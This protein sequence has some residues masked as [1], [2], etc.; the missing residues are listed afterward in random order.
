MHR[1]P[2]SLRESIVH[3]LARVWVPAAVAA[4]VSALAAPA[5]ATTFTVK[6]TCSY[7][8]FPAVCRLCS[9]GLKFIFTA[10]AI[11]PAIPG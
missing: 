8:V 3:R 2:A 7:T 5:G 9:P 4:S 6:N 10:A 11:F 1:S